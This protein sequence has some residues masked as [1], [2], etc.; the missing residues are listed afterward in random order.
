[1][2]VIAI[3]TMMSPRPIASMSFM[4]ALSVICDGLRPIDIQ[5]EILL[6]R[7]ELASLFSRKSPFSYHQHSRNSKRE[8]RQKLVEQTMLTI[9]AL[10]PGSQQHQ[11]EHERD[12]NPIFLTHGIALILAL[13][14]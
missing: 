11:R 10:Q 5:E 9:D 14:N 13:C 1:M 7:E 8:R 3:P 6:N 12:T 2:A 4:N